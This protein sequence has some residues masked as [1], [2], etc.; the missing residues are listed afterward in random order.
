MVAEP[1]SWF[2][3]FTHIDSQ[4]PCKLLFSMKGQQG[5]LPCLLNTSTYQRQLATFTSVLVFK[6]CCFFARPFSRLGVPFTIVYNKKVYSICNFLGDANVYNS[7]HIKKKTIII[8]R[9]LMSHFSLSFRHLIYL[10]MFNRS[11]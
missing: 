2:T 11:E 3:H 4:I 8:Q 6:F 5:K 1:F 10:L 9:M 7:T